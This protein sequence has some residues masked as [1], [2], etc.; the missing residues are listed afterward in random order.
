MSGSPSS[1]SRS[2]GGERQKSRACLEVRVVET[3]PHVVALGKGR[4]G[5]PALV[6]IEIAEGRVEQ[7]LV[8]GHECRQLADEIGGEKAA[9]RLVPSGLAHVESDPHGTARLR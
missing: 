6:P 5:G 8:R 1:R 4:I 2:A 9:A 7:E 3:A